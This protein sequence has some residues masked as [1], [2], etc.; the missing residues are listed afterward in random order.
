MPYTLKGV[1]FNKNS[2]PLSFVCVYKR[3]VEGNVHP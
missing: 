2:T 3:G 1:L